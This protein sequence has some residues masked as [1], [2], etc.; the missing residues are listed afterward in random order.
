MCFVKSSVF[1]SLNSSHSVIKK[2]HSES[3]KASKIDLAY[4]ILSPNSICAVSFA[5]GSNPTMFVIPILYISEKKN[6]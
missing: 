2:A 4:F 1:K 6:K 3:L 5:L